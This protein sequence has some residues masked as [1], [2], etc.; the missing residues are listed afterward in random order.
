MTPDTRYPYTYAADFVRSLAGHTENGTKLSRSDA[1]QIRQGIA[2][3]LAMD[4]HLLATKLADF[5]LANEEDIT[6]KSVKDFSD[7]IKFARQRGG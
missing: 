4:D 1:S 6:E 7:A 3:V 5:Y 2:T